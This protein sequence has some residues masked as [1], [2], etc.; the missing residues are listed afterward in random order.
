[1]KN[2]ILHALNN[3]DDKYVLEAASCIE[4]KNRKKTYKYW[5]MLGMAAAIMLVVIL[6]IVDPVLARNIPIIGSVFEYLQD[7]LDFSGKYNK[8]A[9]TK[10]LVVKSNGVTVE[11]QDAYCDGENLFVS[12]LIK[13]EK[14]FSDYTNEK[15][16][17]T[18]I[19]FDGYVWVEKDEEPLKVDDFGVSGLEGDFVDEYTF[20]GVDTIRLQNGEFPDEFTY[21]CQVF[22]WNLILNDGTE[23]AIRGYWDLSIPVEVNRKDVTEIDVSATRQEHNIDR[24]TVSP[25]MITI[26]TSYPE[27]Y[28]DSVN[29]EVVTFSGESKANISFSAIYGNTE[30]RTWIPRELAGDYLD[31]YV[32][33]NSTFTAHGAKAYE[34]K[35]IEK[36]AIVSTRINISTTQK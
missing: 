33:D 35:E 7:N 4:R 24:V 15:Y 22:K 11:I 12:Y 14:A 1:M 27:L 9:S 31:I 29:Y 19:D 3:V 5:K 18:Q 10:E 34:Q 32:V 21:G 17:K 2:D 6:N 26:Y 36:H 28:N 13:S 25:I 30:G 8:Y 16:L 23:R 20:V